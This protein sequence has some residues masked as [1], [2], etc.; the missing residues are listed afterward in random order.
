M[1]LKIKSYFKQL[2]RGVKYLHDMGVAHRDLKPENLLLCDDGKT[3]KITDFGVSEVF[4]TPFCNATKK[5]KGLCGSGPYIAPEE[6]EAKEYNSEQ[7][8][9]W[10]CGII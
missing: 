9:V 7:V 4:R 8:D 6:F 2:L 1:N 5:A 3:L 10:A